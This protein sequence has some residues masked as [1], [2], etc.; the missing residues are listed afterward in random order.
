MKVV[1]RVQQHN[2]V[3]IYNN[4]NKTFI[5]RCYHWIVNMVG[6]KGLLETI[7]IA[8]LIVA[9]KIAK[10]GNLE[11]RHYMNQS[12]SKQAVGVR[13]SQPD[14]SYL[15]PPSNPALISY[16]KDPAGKKLRIKGIDPLKFEKHKVYLESLNV[17]EGTSRFITVRF[18]NPFS[19]YENRNLILHQDP[20]N[21]NADPKIYDALGLTNWST[22]PNY[23]PLP[24]IVVPDANN[25][26]EWYVISTNL[27]DITFDGKCNFLDLAKLGLYMG[28]SGHGQHDNHANFADINRDGD[29]NFKDM[30]FISDNWLWD[31]TTG[32]L[33]SK[34]DG[35]S[36]YEIQKAKLKR[37]RRLFAN[38]TKKE[39]K[40]R[41][42]AA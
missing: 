3:K 16:L 23:I 40:S 28:T 10:A 26:Q 4:L 11:L 5:N 37:D 29:V 1:S 8:A 14:G 9:P 21:K 7:A 24:A 42:R 19:G 12:G 33:V 20:N 22:E 30:G 13:D 36:R 17:P 31:G 39:R 15:N 34:Y 35:K 41:T 25:A 27:A 32:Q 38:R 2:Q 6:R 18:L